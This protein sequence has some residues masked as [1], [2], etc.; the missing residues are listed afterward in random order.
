LSK[1]A[2]IHL[3]VDQATDKSTRKTVASFELGT[4]LFPY[5][6]DHGFQDMTVVPGS[7]YVELALR[8]HKEWFHAPVGVIGRVEFLNPLILPPETITLTVNASWIDSH[9]ARYVFNETR[10]GGSSASERPCA[11]VEIDSETQA[12]EMGNAPWP[13]V[14]A[15]QARPESAGGAEAFYKRL[16]ENGN[17]YGPCFQTL[18]RIWRIGNEALGLLHVSADVC[19]SASYNLNPIMLDGLAQLLSVFLLDRGQTFILQGIEEIDLFRTKFPQ[20][21]WVYGRLRPSGNNVAR[22]HMGDLDA[23]DNSGAPLMR[24]RGVRFTYLDRV[25]STA[26]TL[27]PKTQIVVASTF[28]AEPIEEPVRF[29]GDYLGLRPQVTFAPYNQVFQE[30]LSPHGQ[31]STNQD[32]FNV[33]LL[34][35][36]DWVRDRH[37][38]SLNFDPVSAA[39]Y[40]ENLERHSLP[41]GIEVAHLNRYETDYLYKEIFEDHCYLRHGI[42]LPENANIIDIGANIG[43]F[44][45]FV[46]SCCAHASVYAFEPSPVAFRAL[47]ANCQAYG[48]GLYPFNTGVS[49]RR[50]TAALTFYEKSTVFSTFHPAVDEDS[51]AIQSVVTNMVRQEL[52]TAAESVDEYVKELVKGRLDWKIF[53]CAVVSVS[54]IVR[55]NGL[56]RVDLL[57]VDAEKCELEILQGIDQELWP[58]IDQ[59][60][61]EVHDR[62]GRKVAEVQGILSQRG[63]RCAVEEEDLLASSGLYHVY[64]TRPST[65]QSTERAKTELQVKADQFVAALDS[66]TQRNGATTILCLC[67]PDKR[68]SYRAVSNQGLSSLEDQLISRVQQLPRV[69][70]IGSQAILDR[71]PTAEFH[72]AHSAEQGHMP[73]TPEGFAAIGTSLCRAVSCVRRSPYKVIVLDCDNTLWQGACGETGPLEVLITP[74]HRLL[75]EFMI[76]QMK[77]GMLL[78][79]CSKNSEADVWAVFES[80]S[81]MI[82]KREHLAAWKINWAPKSQNLRELAADLKL[83]QESFVFLDD[84]PVECA[85]VRANCPETVTLLLPRDPSHLGRFLDHTWAFDHFRVTEEDRTRTQKVIENAQRENYRDQTASLS[86]FI[87]GLQLQVHLFEPGRDQ[88]GRVSQLTLR[89]NQF[90]FTTIR[91]SESEILRFLHQLKG[92]ALAANVSD[93]FGDYGMVGLLLYTISSDCYEVDTFLLSCRALGRGVEH[94]ILAQF[95]RQALDHGKQSVLFQFSHTDKNQAALE[96]IKSVGREFM[97]E[98]EGGVSMRFPAETLANLRYR[99]ELSM[100]DYPF[101]QKSTPGLSR[102]KTRPANA[103]TAT[104]SSEQFQRIADSFSEVKSISSAVEAFR[105][106]TTGGGVIST[107]E[108]L[109]AT[110]IG[111]MLRIWRRVL[112]NPLIGINDNFVDVGG[113]SLKAVQIVA[114]IR[115]ELKVALSIVNIFECPNVELLCGKLDPGQKSGCV[116]DAMERGAKRKERMRRRSE[117]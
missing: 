89:T 112:G 78:C 18:Q 29:W 86:D 95:G 21:T 46:R 70:T 60:V 53:E 105:S 27:A 93:R 10:P 97:R 17:D 72:D 23:F 15:F 85:E 117:S 6:S 65:Q 9:R 34:N 91:R 67:P 79:L 35:L 14:K 62:S 7:M 108:E 64:A 107:D 1:N 19:S 116:D 50:G 92:H 102:R 39:S 90:N 76:R 55:D 75:Q 48:P 59:V 61:V 87:E 13:L 26:N 104:G 5:L 68:N 3:R 12:Q 33:I 98:V 52:G 101:I 38:P 41:N 109:P 2:T 83:S 58:R 88:V 31:F 113:T 100:P 80:N 30:L 57:K 43:L 84:D 44:S 82:L 36:A 77:A 22:G 20:E 47:R 115:R 11:I 66:F 42:R 74:V 45:L 96:F 51:Q 56:Q 110:L 54:D 73:Y 32:G 37:Y 94:R 4:G 71:Y 69:L 8:A 40:F 111:K 25:E 99:P 106:R 49:K 103:S 63:F 28:T 24:L 16:R 114:A 81:G